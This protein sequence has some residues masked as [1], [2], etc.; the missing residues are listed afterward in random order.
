VTDFAQVTVG[1][2]GSGA[3]IAPA[4]QLVEGGGPSALLY[5]TSPFTTVW[6]TEQNVYNSGDAGTLNVVP[7][8]PGQTVVFDGTLDVFGVCPTGQSAVVNVYPSATNVTGAIN[9]TPVYPPAGTVFPITAGAGVDVNLINMV[10]ASAFNSYD[11]NVIAYC[12]SQ[13][14]AGAPLTAQWHLTWYDTLGGSAVYEEDWYTWL[15]NSSATTKIAVGSGPMHGRYFSLDVVNFGTAGTIEITS[16]AVY[17]SGRNVVYS[18]WR[19]NNPGSNQN[20]GSGAAFVNNGAPI[21]GYDN[22]LSLINDTSVASGAKVYSPCNLYAGP[23]G[24]FLA[25]QA[26]STEDCTIISGAGLVN[27]AWVAASLFSSNCIFTIN[28]NSDSGQEASDFDNEI[29]NLPRAPVYFTYG[30]STATGN[31]QFSMIGQQAA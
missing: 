14:T 3:L 24:M 29:T 11:L 19:Q 28:T 1:V 23:V 17:L 5:N 13:S 16:A 20:T 8:G 15:S 27:G 6:L 9:V 18:D 21:G 22:T 2:A 25:T 26:T 10:D 31:I 4:T 7:L 12:N 30:Q